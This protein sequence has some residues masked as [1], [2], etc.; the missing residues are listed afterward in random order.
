MNHSY[1]TSANS[2]LGVYASNFTGNQTTDVVLTQHMD[3]K[4]YPVAG[5]APLGREIYTTAVKFPT[6]GSF[7]R[8]SRSCRERLS[9]DAP[10]DAA[11]ASA[12]TI[13]T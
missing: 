9:S 7:A 1:T 2:K 10:V 3:G 12:T 4:A 11:I 8:A 5:M 6:Y 13:T